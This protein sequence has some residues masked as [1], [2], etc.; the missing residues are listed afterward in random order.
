MG[1]YSENNIGGVR[2][3]CFRRKT[4]KLNLIIIGD[5]FT[6]PEGHAATHRVHS[7]AGGFLENGSNVAVICF[8]NEYG[9][10]DGTYGGY[11]YFFPFSSRTRS[12]FIL[13]RQYR[14][15]LKYINAVKIISQLSQADGIDALIVYSENSLTH[16]FS[17]F[18]SRLFS[19]VL[20]L[21][22]NE[23]PLKNYQSS[24]FKRLKGS[25]RSA[26]VYKL[27]D[28]ILCISDYLVNYLSRRIRR[29]AEVLLVSST[30]DTRKFERKYSRPVAFDYIGYFGNINVGRDAVDILVQAFYLIAKKYPNLHLVMTG[31]IN[32]HDDLLLRELVEKLGI[33]D[34]VRLLGDVNGNLV[35]EYMMNAKLLALPRTIDFRTL[36]SFPSKLT[37][38]LATG[39]PVVSVDVGDISKYVVD[40][41]N[42][43]LVKSPG[44]EAFASKLE[45][46]L[47][48]YRH[49]KKVGL[50]GKKLTSGVFSYKYQTKRIAEFVRH[51]ETRRL[52]L[53]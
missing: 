18:L 35:M 8:K 41:E 7:Y 27:F 9:Q 49:A 20:I 17:F 11:R 6:F 48:N 40:N 37:E 19:A 46:A 29:S 13:I 26:V 25:A 43:F 22:Q 3:S 42:V 5:L 28:G 51:L 23:H 32:A 44:A 34:R 38:Y 1:Q 53:Q 52:S 24:G 2:K 39:I 16:L 21:E 31:S 45:F 30:V 14:K 4:D 15:F 50:N 10:G 47:D 36:A 12:P 33:R